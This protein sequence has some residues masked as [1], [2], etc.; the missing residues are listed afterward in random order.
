MTPIEVRCRL[1]TIRN[2]ELVVA[3]FLLRISLDPRWKP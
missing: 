1:Q 2:I 3:A